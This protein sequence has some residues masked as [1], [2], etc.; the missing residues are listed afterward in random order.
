MFS[1]SRRSIT[2]SQASFQTLMVSRYSVSRAHLPYASH[3]GQLAIRYHVKQHFKTSSSTE[4][5]VSC[6]SF[7]NGM[8]LARVEP[9]QYRSRPQ[10]DGIMEKS[11]GPKVTCRRV[12]SKY[13]DPKATGRN[14]SGSTTWCLPSATEREAPV[15]FSTNDTGDLRSGTRQ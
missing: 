12:V 13:K 4:W 8:L 5:A 11:I 7:C 6:N 15:L 9:P 1:W 2:L 14:P 3:G 10:I